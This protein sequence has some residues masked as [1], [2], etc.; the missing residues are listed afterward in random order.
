MPK[1]K[2]NIKKP[3]FNKDYSLNGLY[4]EMGKY[5]YKIIETKYG[6]DKKVTNALD[7]VKNTTSNQTKQYKRLDFIKVLKKYKAKIK[8]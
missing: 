3:C 1:E 6:S 2:L 7:L 4:F 5:T 8:N